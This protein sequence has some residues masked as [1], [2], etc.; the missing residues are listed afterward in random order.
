MLE[1]KELAGN[2]TLEFRCH[3]R[4]LL[5]VTTLV[6]RERER[7]RNKEELD[8]MSTEKE[9][10]EKKDPRLSHFY[11]QGGISAFSLF[12]PPPILRFFVCPTLFCFLLLLFHESDIFGLQFEIWL[13]SFPP[14]D[15]SSRAP[16]INT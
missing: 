1:R 3:L 16:R 11:V 15:R 13:K 9:E 4:I 8:L 14:E 12:L 7:E 5:T 10:E 6:E 2:P